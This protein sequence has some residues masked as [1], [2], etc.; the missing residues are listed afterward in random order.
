MSPICS[1]S[2]AWSRP[3][4]CSPRCA[5]SYTK[6]LDEIKRI[7]KEQTVD[8][9]VDKEKLSALKTDRDRAF[10]VSEPLEGTTGPSSEMKLTASAVAA[11]GELEKGLFPDR[12]QAGQL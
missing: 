8:I 2:A 9:K 5:C 12:D 6:V 10:K 1:V 3:F 7:R 11:P 4:E